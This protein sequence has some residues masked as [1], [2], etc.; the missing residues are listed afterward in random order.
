[1]RLGSSWSPIKG[2]TMKKC[3]TFGCTNTGVQMYQIAPAT[4]VWLCA[5]CMA[6][7]EEESKKQPPEKR[8]VRPAA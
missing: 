5:Q 7:A 8:D 6:A 3:E 1:M 4:N 2:D